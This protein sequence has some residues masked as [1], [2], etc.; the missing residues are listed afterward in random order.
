MRA[1]AAGAGGAGAAAGAGGATGAGASATGA[2][3]CGRVRPVGALGAGLGSATA[4]GV[5][6]GAACG[7]GAGRGGVE[8]AG[9]AGGGSLGAGGAMNSLISSAGTTTST[10]RRNR[11]DCNAHSA[12]T[13]SAT[14][15]PTMT[16]LR[17]MPPCAAKRSGLDIKKGAVCACVQGATSQKCF[18]SKPGV[19]QPMRD[20]RTDA[21][22]VMQD[23]QHRTD[24]KKPAE[25]AFF[26]RPSVLT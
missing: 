18:L 4:I 12:A 16:A 24:E 19:W 23:G 13:C 9:G 21:D 3:G 26:G 22:V 5:W 17:L 25:P 2:S 15:E 11:P 10:A 6:G 14:T 20:S 1:G 8:G 7:R